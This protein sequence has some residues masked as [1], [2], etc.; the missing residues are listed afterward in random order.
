VSA[1][2]LYEIG[3]D[4]SDTITVNGQ[5]LAPS[6]DP[7]AVLA[8][9]R[10][11]INDLVASGSVGA[12]RVDIRDERE[13]GAGHRVFE[14]TQDSP[15]PQGFDE[16]S[17]GVR[18]ALDPGPRWARAQSNKRLGSA[19]RQITR[20]ITQAAPPLKPSGAQADAAQVARR[21]RVAWLVGGAAVLLLLGGRAALSMDWTGNAY[22][23]V[24]EDVRTGLRVEQ[25]DA[26]GEGR[27]HAWR[28]FP[29]GHVVP[30]VGEMATAGLAIA[31]EGANV[32]E[33][34]PVDGGTVS[35]EG[36]VEASD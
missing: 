20:S 5:T 34:F 14:V 23:A 12:L 27:F 19:R 24:C 32:N 33:A 25:V 29:A 26:C 8:Q 3:V 9:V 1:S 11:Q 30:A 35:R 2:G 7:S 28:Y 16:M 17:P 4:A 21:R 31:P 36:L 13:G 6:A 22:A 10:S 15:L 18:A